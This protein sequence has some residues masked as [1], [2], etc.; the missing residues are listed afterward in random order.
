MNNRFLI[1][2]LCCL[3]LLVNQK[4]HA[5]VKEYSKNDRLLEENV[6]GKVKYISRN[7]Y[8]AKGT[9]AQVQ[10][11]AN[12][13]KFELEFDSAK[14]IILDGRYSMED[15]SSHKAIYTYD[16]WDHE[17]EVRE[18]FNP[19]S[20][21][22][23]KFVNVYNNAGH[24]ITATAYRANGSTLYIDTFIYDNKGFLVES[25][26]IN[27]YERF[28]WKNTYINYAKGTIAESRAY[29]YVENYK[30]YELN[31][32]K[33]NQ[34][35]STGKEIQHKW[36]LGDGRIYEIVQYKYDSKDT[37]VEKIVYSMDSILSR[38]EAISYDKKKKIKETVVISYDE[39]GVPATEY[40]Q[41]DWHGKLLKDT[42]SQ[43][44][45]SYSYHKY[46]NVKEV[47]EIKP[48]DDINSKTTYQYT[49]DKKGNWLSKTTFVNSE[50]KEFVERTIIYYE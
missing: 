23:S 11:V 39:K 12:I 9:I 21:L 43:H 50:A 49:Y 7:V 1:P 24:K 26:I 38:R 48:N 17:I 20:Y 32:I 10:K 40:Q 14:N 44:Y 45:I 36:V 6:Q 33:N 42:S 22:D 28:N 16:K 19:E 34:Y 47:V 46:G 13:M 3:W 30:K 4:L 2:L 15:N 5:Q 27:P 25:Y 41:H 18:Y 37:L 31:F 29:N 8:A 35:S